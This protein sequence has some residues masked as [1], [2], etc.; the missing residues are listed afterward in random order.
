MMEWLANGGW[1]A[2]AMAALIAG[3]IAG[4]D[5]WLR[6]AL[7]GAG[8]LFMLSGLLPALS[9]VPLVLGALL[10]LINAL[11]LL[12]LSTGRSA[13]SAEESLFHQRHL[14]RLRPVDARMLIEQGSYVSARA[15]EELTREG[16]PA[17]TLYFIVQ[18]FAAVLVNDAIVGRVSAGDLIG[19]AALLP[20]GV[21]SATVRIADDKSRLWF[22][23]REQLNLFLAAQPHIATE[24]RSATLAALRDKLERAN[25][26][27]ARHET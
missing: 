23:G 2:L 1:A 6:V 3:S 10:L 18:G 4:G 21:A 22:I 11:A 16:R 27:E 17:D 12:R 14:A 25:R 20:D 15:G 9:P 8:A 19:E 26:A 5:R 24:L 7:A 13:L